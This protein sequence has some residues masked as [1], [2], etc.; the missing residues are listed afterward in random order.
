MN[1]LCIVAGA[2]LV[3]SPLSA[4]IT[5]DVRASSAPNAFGSAAWASYAASALNSLENNL[6][7]IGDRSTDPAAY[8]VLAGVAEAGDM[9]VSSFNSWRG[10]TNPTGAFSSEYGNR[11]HFGLHAYGDGVEQF[12]LEDLTFDV[13]SSDGA[14]ALGFSGDFLGVTFNGTTRIGINWGADR[15]KGGGDDTV[16]ISGNGTT[17]IDELVY[18]G[19]GNAFWPEAVGSQTNE[20]AIE[21]VL[22]YIAA[23]DPF[24]VTGIYEINGHA[25]DSTVRVLTPVPVPMPLAAGLGA[26]GLGFIAS[27]RRRA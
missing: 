26:V 5:L 4:G 18:V 1:R 12:T 21:D 24:S 6:G 3:S 22:A 19:V 15:A 14:N 11:L 9:M 20:E 23:N 10:A 16:Y 2:V 8:E 13:S 7:N 17:L 25:G 27:R